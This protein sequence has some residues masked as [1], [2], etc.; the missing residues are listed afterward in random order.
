MTAM[1]GYILLAVLMG[2]L[3]AKVSLA[4]ETAPSL[5]QLDLS[6]ETHN[7]SQ[8]PLGVFKGNPVIMGMFYTSCEYACPMIVASIKALV[9]KFPVEVQQKIRIL[10]VSFDPERDTPK[11]LMASIKKYDVDSSAWIFARIHAD[12]V[13]L[14]ATSL[15]QKYKKLDNGDFNHTPTLTLLDE[16]GRILGQRDQ[17]DTYKEL[18][19]L[20]L[21]K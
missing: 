14:L 6:L 20:Y 18:V 3:F 8:V 16:H 7:G 19:Q 17:N 10:L 21:N 11:V 2:A 12:E 1:R 9:Q 13:R 5:Y 4:H 15:N